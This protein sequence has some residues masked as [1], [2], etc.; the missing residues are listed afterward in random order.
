M[1]WNIFFGA[2][3]LEGLKEAFAQRGWPTQ[4][5]SPAVNSTLVLVAD[6]PYSP[7]EVLAYIQSKELARAWR[8][9]GF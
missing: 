3:W 7:L 5:F 6:F 1:F 8:S 9:K 4:E 2:P